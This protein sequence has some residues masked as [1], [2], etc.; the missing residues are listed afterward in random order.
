M[1]PRTNVGGSIGDGDAAATE[2]GLRAA[3]DA[4]RTFHAIKDFRDMPLE[5]G[6]G[7]FELP[8]TPLPTAEEANVERSKYGESQHA[9][10]RDGAEWNYWNAVMEAHQQPLQTGRRISQTITRIGSLAI[11]P[12]PGEVFSE[13]ALRI[14]KH[15]PFQYTLCAGTCN[16][17]L[18]YLVTRD[19]RARGGYEVWV[20]RAFSAYL[21]GENLDDVLVVENVRLLKELFNE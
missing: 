14:K 12:F 10:D 1:A 17:H 9:S 2:V 18:G 6:F 19:S 3:T 4:L 8:Y 21:L 11:V 7:E 20:M 13:I 5:L 16:G 15:S